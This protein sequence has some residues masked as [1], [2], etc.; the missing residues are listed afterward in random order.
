MR[1]LLIPKCSLNHPQPQRSQ[2]RPFRC[3]LHYPGSP[4]QPLAPASP[5][6]KGA[7]TIKLLPLTEKGRRIWPQLIHRPFSLIELSQIKTDLG[8]NSDNQ[9]KYVDAF[10][11]LTLA[12]ELTWKDVT[13]VLGQTVSDVEQEKVTKEA[14]KF[15]NNLLQSDNKYHI[16]TS[17]C[18]PTH[19]PWMG[20]Q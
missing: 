11:H 17:N 5:A 3:L 19:G 1:H 6:S 14:R 4:A 13:I 9:D 2:R 12:Y 20:L 18:G 8:N 15:A 16:G 7:L 10:Q